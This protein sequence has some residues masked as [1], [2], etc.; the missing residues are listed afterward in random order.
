MKMVKIYIQVGYDFE[1][2]AAGIVRSYIEREF[3]KKI[4]RAIGT[5]IGKAK[6]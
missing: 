4:I 1:L 3:L 6:I 5:G 2:E